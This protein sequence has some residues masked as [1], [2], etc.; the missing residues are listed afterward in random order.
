MTRIKHAYPDTF[1]PAVNSS[2][3]VEAFKQGQLISPLG[4]EGLHQI[5]NRVS[6]LRHYHEL[7][8]RYSTLTHNCHNIYADA[9]ILEHPLRKAEPHWHGVSPLGR[10]VINEMNRL[11]MLVDLSHTRYVMELIDLHTVHPY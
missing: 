7:G 1:S 4:V 2:T 9:A 10:K 8:V 3:A 5:G 6:N 11:G